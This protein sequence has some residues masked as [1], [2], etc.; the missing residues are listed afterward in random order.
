MNRLSA[1][2]RLLQLILLYGLLTSLW[3]V[4]APVAVSEDVAQLNSRL[5]ASNWDQSAAV[6]TQALPVQTLAESLQW[7]VPGR[8]SD[9]DPAGAAVF[10]RE[11]LLQAQLYRQEQAARYRLPGFSRTDIIYPFHHFW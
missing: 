5:P 2:S 8:M 6:Q 3:S 11:L 4:A 1:I 7:Q 10:R 9:Q